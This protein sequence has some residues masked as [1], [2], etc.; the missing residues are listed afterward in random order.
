MSIINKTVSTKSMIKGNL[1]YL[2]LTFSSPTG[3]SEVYVKTLPNCDDL[4][5][6]VAELYDRFNINTKKLTSYGYM[7]VDWDT[8]I[9]KQGDKDE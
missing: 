5:P 9:A 1:F 8:H 2:Y 6:M 4:E 7:C 3:E